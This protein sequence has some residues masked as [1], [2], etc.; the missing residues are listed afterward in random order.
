[1]NRAEEGGEHRIEDAWFDTDTDTDTD[2]CIKGRRID[3]G[4]NGFRCHLSL[5]L[6]VSARAFPSGPH[7]TPAVSAETLYRHRASPSC[8]SW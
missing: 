7:V 6:S 2:G 5:R 4:G 8:S 1:M 3:G